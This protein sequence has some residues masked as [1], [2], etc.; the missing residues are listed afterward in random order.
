VSTVFFCS[1]GGEYL[2][3]FGS[4]KRQAFRRGHTGTISDDLGVG[5]I[6]TF[7]HVTDGTN[8][9]TATMIWKITA[10]VMGLSTAY[11]STTAVAADDYAVTYTPATVKEL[12]DA[13]KAAFDA[14]PR[15]WMLRLQSYKDGLNIDANNAQD[16][17]LTSKVYTTMNGDMLNMAFA[18]WVKF[19]VNM[20]ADNPKPGSVVQVIHISIKT[21]DADTNEVLSQRDERFAEGFVVRNK[22]GVLP[23]AHIISPG[24][25]DVKKQADIKFV[26]DVDV[27]T[28]YG[29]WDK[30]P[31][32]GKQ[33]TNAYDKFI[34]LPP[35]TRP[36]DQA[37]FNA[38]VHDN[39]TWVNPNAIKTYT[40]T[41][42]VDIKHWTYTFIEP[43]AGINIRDKPIPE[44]KP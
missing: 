6:Y 17:K 3:R 34:F 36:S 30:M 44:R 14:D 1:R 31:V 23:D 19:S 20:P 8:Y 25:V 10:P 21:V 43:S 2:Y 12:A 40:A 11:V 26:T 35:P 24:R 15:M 37:G 39:V 41:F 29:L 28:G 5:P 33:V 7:I 27:T 42:E 38:W 22:S 13:L 9:A 4:G 18:S 16:Q 32:P